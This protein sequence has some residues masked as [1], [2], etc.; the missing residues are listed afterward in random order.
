MKQL[1]LRATTTGSLSGNPVPQ[2]ESLCIAAKDPTWRN[3]DPAGSVVAANEFI[4][5]IAYGILVPQPGIKPT[6][7]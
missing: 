3:K 1:S 2:L 7:S 4:Y 6:D 5:P